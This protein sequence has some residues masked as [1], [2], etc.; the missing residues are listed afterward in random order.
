[1]GFN[2][3]EIPRSWPYLLGEVDWHLDERNAALVAQAVHAVNLECFHG[4][5]EKER[6][7]ASPGRW[8]TNLS[9][10]EG[11]LWVL[12]ARQL[13]LARKLGI[14]DKLPAMDND[15]LGDCNKG[16][17]FIKSIAMAQILWFIIQ[18]IARL[19]N[20]LPTTQLEIMTLSFT[21]CTGITYGFL[22]SKS[23]DVAYSV[24]LPA[25]RRPN[26]AQELMRIAV[27]GPFQAYV[28]WEQ[29]SFGF[30]TTLFTSMKR[31]RTDGV[32]MLQS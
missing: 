18:L 31:R 27:L 19:L 6:F 12:D 9:S 25:S 8:C 29:R 13:L 14:I 21:V 32:I 4:D 17:S 2:T 28:W 26:S 20:R 5:L 11:D 10:L 1:M 23:K 30:R 3:Q 22:L 24:I 7:I 15:D 16:D